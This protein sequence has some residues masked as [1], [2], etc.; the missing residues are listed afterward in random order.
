MAD[1]NPRS[2]AATPAGAEWDAVARLLDDALALPLEHREPFLRESTAPERV[3]SSV[4]ELLGAVTGDR[5][6][7]VLEVVG[8]AAQAARQLHSPPS[9]VGPYEV[10]REVG[11]GGMGVVYLARRA[12][13]AYQRLVALKVSHHRANESDLGARFLQERDILAGLAHPNIVPLFDAGVTDEGLPFFTMEFVNGVAIDAFCDRNMLDVRA[14]IRLFIRVCQ[15]VAAAHR[16]LVV[17]RDLKSSNVL[18]TGDA[19][20][21]LL[22]FGIATL[23]EENRPQRADTAGADLMTPAYASPEQVRGQAVST[24]TDVYALGLMLYELLS[25]RRAHRFSSSAIAELV[26]VVAEVEPVPL[27]AAVGVPEDPSALAQAEVARRRGTS[28]ARLVRLLRGDLEHIASKALAKRPEQ[29]YPSA[30]HLAEDLERYLEGRAVEA[31]GAST[32]YSVGRILRRHRMAVGILAL[33]T[34]ALGGYAA[35][36]AQHAR[37]MAV[38]AERERLEAT[39]AREVADFIVS[40]F[41]AAD[42]TAAQST[43]VSVGQ[44]LAQGMERAEALGSQPL[45]QARLLNAVGRAYVSVGQM[46]AAAAAA[47]RAIAITNSAT[48]AAHA[49]LARDRRLLGLIAI[50]RGRPDEAIDHFRQAVALHQQLPSAIPEL[51]IDT[52]HLAYA[53]AQAGRLDEAEPAARDALM[54]TASAHPAGSEAVS[55]SLS[56]LAFVRRRQ[57]HPLDAVE[58]YRK[59]LAIDEQRLGKTHTVVARARQNLAVILTD[60]G[61]FDDA[62]RQLTQAIAAYRAVFGERH[63]RIATT[64]NNLGNLESRRNR[65]DRA[66][67]YTEAAFEMRRAILGGDHAST[68]LAQANL[69]SLLGSAG[70]LRRGEAMLRDVLS[71]LPDSSKT[72]GPS[73]S[74]TM[75]NLAHILRQ[76]GRLAE[77]ERVGRQALGLAR[78]QRVDALEEAAVLGTLGSVLV[79]RGRYAEAVSV[80]EPAVAIRRERLGASNDRTA[81]LQRELDAARQG[82]ARRSRP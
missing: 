12:D 4:R 77:A 46:D 75:A 66:A 18:V 39:H 54:R 23:L 25:G 30:M 48:P 37:E 62:E 81:R 53:L 1:V 3:V 59:A 20:V 5:V 32:I 38:V 17:H 67:D 13:G 50:E 42:P 72:A 26:R 11:R 80:L 33:A 19:D 60:L 78:A 43:Q 47:A 57:G 44:L 70:H 82:L 40:L 35:L 14:R 6:D 10:L 73:K 15:A 7:A 56:T 29:R 76:Q 8:A 71:R 74:G 63:P 61:Q 22:D 36:T 51:A 68:L 24:A 2:T 34:G 31:R 9:R 79:A 58:L 69:G 65:F 27:P 64:L 41:E 52:T 21:K 16:G 55:D 28:V 49:D 45:L